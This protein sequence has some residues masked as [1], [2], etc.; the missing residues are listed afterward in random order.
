MD[1]TID[2]ADYA[3]IAGMKEVIAHGPPGDLCCVY[4]LN[5]LY[6]NRPTKGICW[7]PFNE[8]GIYRFLVSTHDQEQIEIHHCEPDKAAFLEEHWHE[9][10]E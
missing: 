6:A 8:D 3:D 9:N 1:M 10:T 7:G 2:V 5:P 4:K